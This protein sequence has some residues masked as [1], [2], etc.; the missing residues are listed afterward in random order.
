[1]PFL[2]PQYKQ[3][4]LERVEK[5]YAEG[6]LA[7][8]YTLGGRAYTPEQLIDEARRGTKVGEEFLFAEKQLM[9][10]LKKRM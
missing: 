2:D 4:L 5:R 6:R 1:M 7:P 3:K 9:D 10:E 8:V